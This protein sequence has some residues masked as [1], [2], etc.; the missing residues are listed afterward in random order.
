MGRVAGVG[1]RG[2][3]AGV[4]RD[5]LPRQ[6]GHQPGQVPGDAT[7]KITKIFQRG[8]ITLSAVRLVG[9]MMTQGT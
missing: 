7:L 6:V 3:V 2:V 4:G 8:E 9:Q 5:G 1:V